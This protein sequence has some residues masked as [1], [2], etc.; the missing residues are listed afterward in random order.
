MKTGWFKGVAW[1]LAAGALAAGASPGAGTAQQSDRDCLC[2]DADGNEIENCTCFRMP[3]VEAFVAP[4]VGARPRL[5]I[6][7]RTSQDSELDALGAE[8]TRVME[9]GPADEAGI[10]ENDVITSIDG[11]SLFEPLAGDI[12]DD[13]DLDE[14]IPVQRLL[15]IARD[16]EPGQEVEVE[17]LR[18]GERRAATVE[19]EDLSTRTF[20]FVGPGFDEERL[21]EQVERIRV[22]ADDIR[23]QAWDYRFDP[24]NGA[25]FRGG[26]GPLI[27]GGWDFRGHGLELVALTPTLGE[28]FGVTEGVLVTDVDDDST[29]GLRPGDVILRVGDRDVTTPARVQRIL[30]SYAD[31]EEIVFRV[32]R[33]GSAIDVMG[34]LDD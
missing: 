14:S 8:V 20:S 17:Y 21:R 5:G 19:A 32:Q 7:V 2:V 30:G 23:D 18:D 12:E 31:D 24:P 16:L 26:D 4:F 3:D 1:I 10:R 13:F 27:L 33:Q 22:Y 11:H 9:D 25:V 6:S 28:Y 34:R 15:A 29:L